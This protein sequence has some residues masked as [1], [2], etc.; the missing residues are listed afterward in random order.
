M[1]NKH[2]RQPSSIFLNWLKLRCSS[3]SGEK[4]RYRNRCSS[5]QTISGRRAA[6]VISKC[7]SAESQSGTETLETE[8]ELQRESKVLMQADC[9]TDIITWVTGRVKADTHSALVSE[10]HRPR[11]SA[12]YKL[13][14]FITPALQQLSRIPGT[15]R[16]SEDM[17]RRRRRCSAHIA[18]SVQCF[19]GG[20]AGSHSCCTQQK[21]QQRPSP[22][23][24]QFTERFACRQQSD[25]RVDKT[26]ARIS[27]WRW[28]YFSDYS[29]TSL[30]RFEC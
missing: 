22:Q 23:L 16:S 18:I 15:K 27:S 20:T 9:W 3:L 30:S 19:H 17:R 12:R 26:R 2:I 6:R 5:R 24:T 8:S 28:F 10:S 21:T 29:K 13:F 25:A 14:V 7:I 11:P 4:R 1:S